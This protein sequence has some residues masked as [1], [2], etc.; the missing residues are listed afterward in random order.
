M[1][2]LDSHNGWSLEE[3]IIS[4]EHH[5]S[6]EIFHLECLKSETFGFDDL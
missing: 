3:E 5:Y 2:V 6:F 1:N 4:L